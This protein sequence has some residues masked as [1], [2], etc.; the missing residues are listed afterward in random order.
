MTRLLFFSDVHGSPGALRRL[1]NH[2]NQL[3]PDRLILLGDALYH[4]PRNPLPSDYNPKEVASILNG[5]KTRI[6]AIRGN[7]DSEVDQMMLDF[8][9]LGDYSM[10]LADG[11]TFFLTHG[12]HFSPDNPPPLNESDSVLAYG[13]THI[14]K[15]ER[16]GGLRIFNPGS[17]TSPKENNPPTFGWYD[18]GEGLRILDL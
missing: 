17:V 4:G 9:I 12:H 6:L 10:L 2:M 18:S 7:C 16:C 14:P 15:N 3:S 13:H 8:P 1:E 5:W 11:M